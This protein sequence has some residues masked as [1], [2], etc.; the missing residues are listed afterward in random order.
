MTYD[1]FLSTLITYKP[2]RQSYVILA[3]K[4]RVPCL[5][6]GIIH[7]TL[8]DKQII[9]HDVLHVPHLQNPLLSVCCLRRLQGCSFLADNSGSYLSF[10]NF[11]IPVDDSSHC[12]IPGRPSNPCVTVD[13]DSRLF[14][15]VAAISDN[16]RF[17]ASR[18]P[19]LPS[20]KKPSIPSKEKPSTPTCSSFDVPSSSLIL[21]P[22]TTPLRDPLPPIM[23]HD[24]GTLISSDVSSQENSSPTP[25]NSSLFDSSEVSSHLSPKQ[26]QELVY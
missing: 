8:D 14:G 16:T 17:R 1:A 10:P 25:T 23:E 22:D 4:S 26:I 11:I 18:R 2:C 7:L 13:F 20:K 15:S 21:P 19:I 5:G 9:L 24:D 6:R 3:D 12:I